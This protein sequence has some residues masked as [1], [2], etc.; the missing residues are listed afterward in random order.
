M[1]ETP[2]AEREILLDVRGPR[3]DTGAPVSGQKSVLRIAFERPWVRALAPLCFVLIIGAVFNAQGSFFKWGTHRDMLR[4]VSVYGILACGMTLVIITGGIDLAVGS[5][6]G[7]CAVIFSI[8]SIHLGWSAWAAIPLVVLAGTT[9]GLLSGGMVAR[10]RMQP[11]IAT[12]AVMV[13]ARGLAKWVSGGQKISSAVLN[14]DGSYK[15]VDLP[16][17]FSALDH[18]ILGE[19]IAVVT[20]IFLACIGLCR[21]LLA[22]L[23]WGRYFYATGGNEELFHGV[24]PGCH[25]RTLWKRTAATMILPVN[26]RRLASPTALMLRIF[27]R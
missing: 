19:N 5:I 6:L 2:T 20:L 11:F 25:L 7:V 14:P 27:S 26:M 21:V 17:I 4:Q 15:Y 3:A 22:K 8:L 9:C 1:N 10:F 13:F 12:L 23:R 24:P 18:K 16:R